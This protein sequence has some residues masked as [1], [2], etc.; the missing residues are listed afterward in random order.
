[1]II[2]SDFKGDRRMHGIFCFPRG[3]NKRLAARHVNLVRRQRL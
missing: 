3:W 2:L 1:M